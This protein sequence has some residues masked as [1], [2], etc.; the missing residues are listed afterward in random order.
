MNF[1]ADTIINAIDHNAR[2]LYREGLPDQTD[3]LAYEVGALRGKVRELCALLH[4]AH[5]EIYTLQTEL[6]GQDK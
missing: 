2:T 1:N 5:E 6:I 3:R 4:N